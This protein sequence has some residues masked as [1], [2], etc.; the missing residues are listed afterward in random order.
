MDES[1]DISD[2]A[3]LLIFIRGV[4]EN[5]EITEELLSLQSIKGTTTG[6]DIFREF[7]KSITSLNL[8]INKLVN[9]TTDGATNMIGKNIGF[10]GTFKKEYPEVSVVFLHCIIHQD[11][12]CNAALNVKEVL[13]VIVSVVNFIRSRALHHRQFQDFL[14]SVD[15]EYSDLIYYTK[16]RWLSAGKVFERVWNLKNEII[17]FL[18]KL[19]KK[20]KFLMFEDNDW[21]SDFA[22]FTDFFSHLNKLNIK[23]QGKNQFIDVLWSNIKSFKVQLVLFKNQLLQK[24]F[25]HFPKLSTRNPTDNKLQ[26]YAEQLAKLYNEFEKRFEDFKQLETDINTFSTPFMVNAEEV[27]PKYQI[28]LIE[29]QNNIELKQ[30]F[31]NVPKLEFY[32]KLNKE[33]FPNLILHAQKMI[34]IF[35]SSYVCEQVFSTMKLRKSSVRNRLTDSHLGSILRISSSQIEPNFDEIVEKQSQFH[36]ASS[37]KK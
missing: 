1:T 11:A 8:N 30:M 35:G 19:N 14:Q 34:A 36:F 37:S 33:L 24:D 10:K 6:L 31:L 5:F 12:L 15:A 9:I 17:M 16:V 4:D 13:E 3:Q 26:L 28:E 25:T 2:T 18:E 21:I 27:E 22:F 32:K 20:E 7:K 23:L 29:L